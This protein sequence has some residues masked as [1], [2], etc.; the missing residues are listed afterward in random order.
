MGLRLKMTKDG[1]RRIFPM[2]NVY[3]AQGAQCRYLL[4]LRELCQIRWNTFGSQNE[5]VPPSPASTSFMFQVFKNKTS[6]KSIHEYDTV[7]RPKCA[8]VQ[9]I[10][11][12]GKK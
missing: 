1:P 7:S 3:T 10:S 6:N 12:V 8:L 9:V 11:E 4:L 2:S 5:N